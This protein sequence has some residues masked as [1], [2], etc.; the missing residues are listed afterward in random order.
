MAEPAVK[1]KRSKVVSGGGATKLESSSGTLGAVPAGREAQMSEA[2]ALDLGVLNRHWYRRCLDWLDERLRKSSSSP[3]IKELCDHIITDFLTAVTGQAPDSGQLQFPADRAYYIPFEGDWAESFNFAKPFYRFLGTATVQQ[4]NWLYDDSIWSFFPWIERFGEAKIDPTGSV[5]AEYKTIPFE[6]MISV[7]AQFVKVDAS[8]RKRDDIADAPFLVEKSLVLRGDDRGYIARIMESEESRSGILEGCQS[9]L[10]AV[11]RIYELTPGNAA[12]ESILFRHVTL[13]RWLISMASRGGSGGELLTEQDESFKELFA[14]FLRYFFLAIPFKESFLREIPRK[15][16]EKGLQALSALAAEAE[17]AADRGGAVEA[18]E[19]AQAAEAARRWQVLAELAYKRNAPFTRW[20]SDR[21]SERVRKSESEEEELWKE[22]KTDLVSFRTF[23]TADSERRIEE[24]LAAALGTKLPKAGDGRQSLVWAIS[25]FENMDR[26]LPDGLKIQRKDSESERKNQAMV[27]GFSLELTEAYEAFFKRFDAVC[28]KA[29]SRPE[30]IKAYWRTFGQANRRPKVFSSFEDAAA[31]LFKPRM[32][33]AQAPVGEKEPTAQWT[34]EKARPQN[35]FLRLKICDSLNEP[36]LN[37]MFVI[38]TDHDE[39]K[40]KGKQEKVVRKDDLEDLLSFAKVYF[41]TFRDYLRALDQAQTALDIGQLNQYLYD[42]RLG[43]LEQC[44]QRRVDDPTFRKGGIADEENWSQFTYEILNNYGFSLLTKPPEVQSETF[45]YDRLLI[46][47]LHLTRP[48]ASKTD[49]VDGSR[50]D[51]PFYLFQS[52]FVE[53]IAGEVQG[54]RYSLIK[55]FQSPIDEIKTNEKERFRVKSFQQILRTGE[56]EIRLDRYLEKLYL[57]DE[58]GLASKTGQVRVEG[59]GGRGEACEPESFVVKLVGEGDLPDRPPR[60]RGSD[61][62][63]MA[64]D[65]F[66]ARFNP[67]S[68]DGDQ[69]R[70]LWQEFLRSLTA[71][72]RRLRQESS[73]SKEPWEEAWFLLRFGLLR[74]LLSRRSETDN[75]FKAIQNLYEHDLML[76]FDDDDS[77]DIVRLARSSKDPFAQLAQKLS[78]LSEKRTEVSSARTHDNIRFVQFLLRKEDP[79]ILRFFQHLT[80]LVCQQGEMGFGKATWYQ[81]LL[82]RPFEAIEGS[83]GEAASE[84]VPQER[85][86][87]NLVLHKKAALQ[88]QQRVPPYNDIQSGKHALSMFLG[89]VNLRVGQGKQTS[90]LRCLVAMIRDYDDTKTGAGLTPEEVRQQLE[91]DLRDLGLYTTTFFR[92]VQKFVFDAMRGEANRILLTDV[93]QIARNWYSTGMDQI[94]EELSRRLEGMLDDRTDFRLGGLRP[95]MV[96][97]FFD[98]ILDVLL[99]PEERPSAE[100]EE[101]LLES[102][103]FD[104][105]LHIPLLLGTSEGERLC[106]ARTQIQDQEGVKSY[107]EIRS[108]GRTWPKRGGRKEK[109]LPVGHFGLR[110]SRGAGLSSEQALLSSQPL[111]ELLGRIS[112]PQAFDAMVRSLYEANPVQTLAV[113]GLIRHLV[114]LGRS[115][116]PAERYD[117]MERRLQT[118]LQDSVRIVERRSASISRSVVGNGDIFS[119]VYM[120]GDASLLELS[121]LTSDQEGEL[122]KRLAE[123]KCLPVWYEFFAAAEG[124]LDSYGLRSHRGHPVS[125]KLFYVYYSLDAPRDFTEV[126]WLDARFRGVFTFVVDDASTDIKDKEGMDADQQDIRTFIHNCVRNLRLFLEIQSRENKIRQPGVESFVLGMLHRLKND[127]GKP[128]VVLDTLRDM[129]KS[130]QEVDQIEGAKA[131]IMGLKDLFENLREL[132]EMQRGFVPMRPYSTNWLGWLFLAKVCLAAKKIAEELHRETE[133]ATAELHELT[134]ISE[135]AEAELKTESREPLHAIDMI[136][137]EV[138]ELESVLTDLAAHVSTS[139]RKPEVVLAFQVFSDAPLEF[140]GSFQLEEAFNVLFE[141]AFQAFWSYLSSVAGQDEHS[142]GVLKV[143][144]SKS[145]KVHDEVMFEIGNSSQPIDQGILDVLNDPVP[146]PM[147]RRQH[148]TKTRKRGGSGFGHYYARRIVGD[149]CGG[150]KARRKLDVH[151]DYAETARLAK[152]RVNLM[153]AEEGFKAITT[154]QIVIE[155]SRNFVNDS[156]AEEIGSLKQALAVATGNRY[157]FP[158]KFDIED[159]FEVIRGLLIAKRE[160]VENEFFSWWQS[161]VCSTLGR[162]CEEV[163]RVLVDKLKD[164]SPDVTRVRFEG[165]GLARVRRDSFH[166]L[167]RFVHRVRD[168]DRSLLRQIAQSSKLLQKVLAD[169]IEGGNLEAANLLKPA[170]RQ[171]AEKGFQRY[172]PYLTRR[173]SGS[174]VIRTLLIDLVEDE[175]G[176]PV[177]SRDRLVD[178]LAKAFWS[179]R[180]QVENGRLHLAVSLVDGDPAKIVVDLTRDQPEHPRDI[181]PPPIIGSLLPPSTRMVALFSDTTKKVQ[182]RSAAYGWRNQRLAAVRSRRQAAVSSNLCRAGPFIWCYG[183]RSENLRTLWK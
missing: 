44:M 169:V 103:P 30:K 58:E 39:V 35:F 122:R 104:R 53:R 119:D 143:V 7:R 17:T 145:E 146:Q 3:N 135:R 129:A 41:F 128:V 75:E 99:R 160:A 19:S 124:S 67:A 66:W 60:D 85:Q 73:I 171:D 107:E 42:Q 183:S 111:M 57:G 132:S 16:L 12:V 78:L 118:V 161:D 71:S 47:P 87:P 150:R 56:R 139:E 180:A 178:L 34:G 94:S 20:L 2:P 70:D 25:D 133:L 69:H 62:V 22:A 149:L 115:K 144:A 74:V 167:C 162:R 37:G 100:G 97:T 141:N 114:Q 98:S 76:R 33:T 155:V 11:F 26:S 182:I 93:S 92:N 102:F 151:I 5:D 157:A 18:D 10:H 109:V 46:I 1:E 89:L 51:L 65:T 159:L 21:R 138:R 170:D 68:A 142:R 13:I 8:R 173:I 45:P 43:D 82:R 112:Q 54:D 84:S 63:A 172:R 108:R 153:A 158:A 50:H 24:D 86:F 179:I 91:V 181:T 166:D 127:L 163:R 125:S 101:I 110:P 81:P 134:R 27:L 90:V 113:A 117:E 136:Q 59:A 174:E 32:V 28:I 77:L 165:D 168:R 14:A 96:D 72:W 15:D 61:W 9:A 83:A 88:I 148:S 105:L 64:V 176:M 121:A 140:R 79:F 23:L 147:T 137:R 95:E 130:K 52:I 126:P 116:L 106:Y 36:I 31:G 156:Q 4:K 49:A 48:F 175:H 131:T 177:P 164:L 55:P 29:D 6:E 80:D 123:I 120:D 40:F 152:V 38:S 154:D